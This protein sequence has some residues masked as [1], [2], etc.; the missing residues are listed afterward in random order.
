L[1]NLTD[2]LARGGRTFDLDAKGKVRMTRIE[3]IHLRMDAE[4]AGF[5][6]VAKGLL[7]GAVLLVAHEQVL[8][9]PSTT[10]R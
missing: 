2:W 10:E 7:R 1:G 4:R 6:P 5:K 8:T 9:P 3:E